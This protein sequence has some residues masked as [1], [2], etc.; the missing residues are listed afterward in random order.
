MIIPGDIT[1]IDRGV[2][3]HQVNCIYSMGSGV[4]RELY[5][6]FPSVRMDYLSKH[7]WALGDVQFIHINK[8]LYVANMA[9]QYSCGND[10]NT[11]YT[12]ICALTTCFRKLKKFSEENNLPAYVPKNIGCGLGNENWE[13]NVYPMI[14]DIFPK[15]VIVNYAL[16]VYPELKTDTQ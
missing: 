16:N 8:E 1:L 5:T 10:K 12:N 2:I 7:S 6:K 9:G 11:V 15:C 3:G 13:E 14:L 4:A